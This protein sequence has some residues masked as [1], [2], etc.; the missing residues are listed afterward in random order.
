MNEKVIDK[1]LFPV[2]KYTALAF[3][4]ST[5]QLKVATLSGVIL[6]LLSEGVTPAYLEKPS[7][8]LQVALNPLPA[9]V[10]L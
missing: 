2:P 7:V 8:Q 4:E 9:F 10:V 6:T 5:L 3:V 1:V